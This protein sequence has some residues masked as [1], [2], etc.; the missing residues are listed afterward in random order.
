M[1]AEHAWLLW[2]LLQLPIALTLVHLKGQTPM[3]KLAF[4]AFLVFGVAC[5]LYLVYVIA[6]ATIDWMASWTP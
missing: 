3:L 2:L 4:A 1:S 5:G 6:D